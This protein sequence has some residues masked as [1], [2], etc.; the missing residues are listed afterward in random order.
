MTICGRTVSVEVI[1]EK[2][3]VSTQSIHQKDHYWFQFTDYNT[4][5][6]IDFSPNEIDKIMDAI[7]NAPMLSRV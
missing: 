3:I 7:F 4:S 1:D 2:V 6:I 5:Q